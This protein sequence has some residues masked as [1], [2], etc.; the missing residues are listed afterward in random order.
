MEAELQSKLDVL[1]MTSHLHDAE[2]DDEQFALDITVEHPPA[3][4]ADDG[5]GQD[6]EGGKNGNR[7]H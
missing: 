6:G 7:F 4:A 3:S 2:N 1:P 5:D